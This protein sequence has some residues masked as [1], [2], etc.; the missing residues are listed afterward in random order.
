MA[1]ANDILYRSEKGTALTFAELDNNFSILAVAIDNIQISNN[2]VVVVRDLSGNFSANTITANL[3]G[4]SATTTKF[5]TARTIN[6]VSFDGTANITVTANTTN[7]LTRGTYLTGSNFNGSA[8]TTW[9]VDADSL[10][11]ASKVVARD[12]SGNFNANTISAA[13]VG[14]ASTATTL[15]TARTIGDVSFNGSASIVPE[16][17]TYKD[18]RSVDFTPY[19]YPGITLHI[20]TNTTDSLSDSGTYHGVLNL[21][22]W[23]DISGGRNHQLGFTD[24]GNVHHR[25]S[26]NTTIWSTWSKLYD[27]EDAAS[28][29]TASTLVLRDSSGNFSANTITAT[30]FS[31]SF[32][33]TVSGNANTA[34]TLQT[35]RTI[36]GVSFNGS[37]NITVPSLYDTNY[38]RITNPGGAEYVTT[39]ATVT[40]AIEIV[41]PVGYTNTMIRMTVKIFEYVSGESFT[42]ECGGYNYLPTTTWTMPF[43]YITSSQGVDR[44][45]SVRFGLNAAGKAVVYIGELAS[46]WS[47]PQVYVTDVQLGYGG[48]SATW[49]SGWAINFQ[50]TA[51]ENVTQTVTNPQIGYAVSTNTANSVVLRDASGNFSANTITAT[52]F[53]GSFTGTVS[54][55][56]STVTNGVYT[57]DSVLIAR[58]TVVS[59][60]STDFNTIVTAGNYQV[61]GNGTWTGSNNAPSAAYSYGQ[62]VVTVNGNI[63]TQFYYAHSTTGHFVRSKFNASDWQVWQEVLTSSNYNSYAPTLTGTGASGT[64]GISITGSANTATSSGTASNSTQLDGNA[65]TSYLR[66]RGVIAETT[67]NDTTTDAARTSG[68]YRVS[69][70]GATDALLDIG[71]IGGSTPRVQFRFNYNDDIWVRAARDTETTWDSLTSRGVKL[72]HSNNYTSF[73]PTLTGTGASGTWNI[74]ITGSANTVSP[75]FTGQASFA[76][77]SAAAPSIT[78]TG[79]LNAG[80]FFPAADTVAVS[81]A[82]TERMRI[83]SAGNISAGTDTTTISFDIGGVINL[84]AAT[85]EGRSIE[86]GGGRAGNGNSFIDFI[87]DATYTDFGLRIIRNSTGADTNSAIAHRGTGGLYLTAQDAGFVGFQTTNTTRFIIGALGQFG[88]G[89]ATYGT[90]GQV[91]TSGGA[92]AAPSWASTGF[93]GTVI[94]NKLASRATATTYQNTTN[95]WIL[96]SVS[97]SNNGQTFLLGSTNALG[98]TGISMNVS[99]SN[100]TYMVPPLWYYRVTGTVISVWTEGQA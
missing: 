79:D 11:T 47:Y 6:G 82:G 91:M 75:A 37:A 35:A 45:F 78:H 16:R 99:G 81:T 88:I 51:F 62:L 61:S 85:T 22:H 13:L 33:G 77:G 43:A 15:Q 50:A 90:A 98:I 83:T 17:I 55:N 74:S 8:A 68:F 27:T 2:S 58:A 40:G 71:G 24:A 34:T 48:Q 12:S 44:R 30:T 32:T 26:T 67:L 76:D 54:G 31:G 20:K 25:S 49:V 14:N 1:I 56:A 18:T 73:A 63:V 65:E 23:G 86:I 100:M 10:A 9:A 36:N 4:N 97:M 21:T 28:T 41:L 53:S 93:G 59:T 72:L 42:V 52:T 5:L 69:Y 84:P 60:N 57:T 70:P 38:R 29:A 94:T 89:G 95:G 87:G 39:T 66:Y 64:W 19:T 96:V 46:T 80:L 3:A 7:T 92:S